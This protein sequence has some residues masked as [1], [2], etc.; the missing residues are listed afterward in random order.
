[1]I[2]RLAELEVLDAPSSELPTLTLRTAPNWTAL[3]FFAALASLHW[4][5]AVPAFY[6]QRWEG[7]FS[8]AFAVLFTAV[9][10]ACWLVASELSIDPARRQIRMRS[11]LGRISIQRS[12]PFTDVHGVRVTHSAS[13]SAL[14]CRVEVLCDNEDLECPPTDSPHQQALVMAMMMNVR[15]IKVFP[16]DAEPQRV[17]A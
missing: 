9:A 8:L 1:M 17:N 14:A 4:A 2:N 13:R 16:S 6:R 3:V 5:V 7:L 15:L 11:G 10:L 12:I